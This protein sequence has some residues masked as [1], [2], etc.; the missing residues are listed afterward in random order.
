V[1]GFG[2]GGDYLAQSFRSSCRQ[3]QCNSPLHP[4]W[5]CTGR[6]PVCGP[7]RGRSADAPLPESNGS[8]A[9]IRVLS[10]REKKSPCSVTIATRLI[11]SPLF[12]PEVLWISAPGGESGVNSTYATGAPN[13]DPAVITTS[14][15]GC[16]NSH[17]PIAVNGLDSKGTAPHGSGQAAYLKLTHQIPHA[18]LF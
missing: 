7:R 11:V 4:G 17:Y 6:A 3:A 16:G 9:I 18:V 14:R 15:T 1:T 8:T 5:W 13:Y 10:G 12:A 2:P